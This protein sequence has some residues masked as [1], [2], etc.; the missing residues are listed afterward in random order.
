MG[1]EERENKRRQSVVGAMLSDTSDISDISE[2]EDSGHQDSSQNI[3]TDIDVDV[4]IVSKPKTE[5]RSKRINLLVTPSVYA[6]ARKK[7]KQMGISLNECINQF[8]TNWTHT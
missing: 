8:L 3:N 2:P 5:T 6:E 1:L 4:D 7:C